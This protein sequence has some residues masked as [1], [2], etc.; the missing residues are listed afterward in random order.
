MM[1]RRIVLGLC[2]VLAGAVL[3]DHVLRPGVA[4]LL[5]KPFTFTNNTVADAT[6]V[7]SDFDT[8]YTWTGDNVDAANIDETDDYAWTGTHSFTAPQINDT[9][10]DHQY[11]FGVSE[12]AADRTVTLPLLTGADTFVFQSHTQTLS[13]KTLTS[14]TVTGAPT[15]AGATWTDLGAVTTADI[16]GGTI[17]GTTIGGST[18]AAGAFTTLTTTGDVQVGGEAYLGLLTVGQTIN[19]GMGVSGSTFTIHQ[20]DG[21]A[22][23]ASEPC[24]VGVRSSTGGRIVVAK[25]TSNVTFTFGATSDTDGNVWGLDSTADWTPQ[26]PFFVGVIY[27]GTSS[28]FTISRLPPNNVDATADL[29]QKGDTD[30]DAQGDVMLL[31]SGETL[32]NFTNVPITYAGWFQ[33]T[34]A[35]T[36]SAWTARLTPISS[37]GDTVTG[38]NDEFEKSQWQYDGSGHN[39]ADNGSPFDTDGGTPPVFSTTDLYYYI[40]RSREVRYH[41]YLTG[42]GGTDGVGASDIKLTL[43]F[44]N[45]GEIDASYFLARIALPTGE[46][47]GRATLGDATSHVTFAIP[48]LSGTN[49]QNSTNTIDTADFT[50]GTRTIGTVIIYNAKGPSG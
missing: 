45:V 17:D 2:C 36:G 15:A 44:Q 32:A 39:G 28:Y 33:M 23:S 5:V 13:N 31:A 3:H 41:A 25:F 42:D 6:E 16:N 11:V 8:L 7:N 27:N 37:P 50:N 48:T 40:K 12:L 34:Y 38:F 19:C 46:F 29:C 21:S 30:C 9:S 1:M 47:I 49:L 35:T 22:L 14:P 10:A 4:G 20:A 24:F 26:M 18:P 43:P